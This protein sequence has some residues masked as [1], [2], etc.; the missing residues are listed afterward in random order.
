MSKRLGRIG[1]YE[2][3]F[4]ANLVK[5]KLEALGVD[6]VLADRETIR[7]D[8]LLSNA[9]RG[10]KV[11]VPGLEVEEA[12]CVLQSEAAPE[13]DEQDMPGATSGVCPACGSSNTH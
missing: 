3:L 4:E 9:L 5:P 8:K 13:Q 12:R 11:Q 1:S 2:T 7:L 10:I 6:A